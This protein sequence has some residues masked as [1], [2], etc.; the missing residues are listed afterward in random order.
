MK[1]LYYQKNKDY[2]CKLKK[3]LYCLKQAPRA[4]FSRLDNHLQQ[5]GYKRGAIHSNLYIEIEK[6]N[7]IIVVV[8]VDGIVFGSNLNPPRKKFATKMQK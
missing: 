7:M 2:V 3:S 1:D 5:Q 4:W 8:Y 6:Q